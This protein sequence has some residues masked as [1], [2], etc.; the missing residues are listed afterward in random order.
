MEFKTFAD[1]RGT[2]EEIC[3]GSDVLRIKSVAGSKRASH[4]H[5]TTN[6]WCVVLSGCIRYYERP[7]GSN[8][9]PTYTL[10]Q[11]GDLFFTGPMLEH[12]MA[13]SVDTEFFCFSGGDRNQENYENDLVRLPE[14]LDVCYE[15]LLFPTK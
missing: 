1:N 5:K 12:T 7:V 2:I 10:Y 15:R 6:H 9:L 13:F 4:Y 8:E 11:P 14:D 3:K